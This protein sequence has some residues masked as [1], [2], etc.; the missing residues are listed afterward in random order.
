MATIATLK[1]WKVHPPLNNLNG[2]VPNY[3]EGAIY[4]D[5]I[6]EDGKFVKISNIQAI[7]QFPD[8]FYIVCEFKS[9]RLWKKD[10]DND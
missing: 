4:D 1:R 7:Q 2:L 6:D 5:G 8:Y 3:I 9:Y 10:A